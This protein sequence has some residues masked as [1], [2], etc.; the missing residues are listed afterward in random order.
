[1]K[2]QP[3]NKQPEPPLAGAGAPVDGKAKKPRPLRR[4][5]KLDAERLHRGV[6]WVLRWLIFKRHDVTVAWVAREAGAKDQ[7]VR[8]YLAYAHPHGWYIQ[9]LVCPVL[10][11]FPDEVERLARRWMRK[12]R[13]REKQD[14]AAERDWQLCYPWEKKK[15]KEP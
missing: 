1:M 5:R 13:R 2:S 12:F 6:V 7:S 8:D 4:R 10:G 14:H 15:E 3:R 11:Y 9:S